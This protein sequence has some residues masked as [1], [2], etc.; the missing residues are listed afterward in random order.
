MLT[1]ADIE[2]ARRRIRDAV[3]LTPFAYTETLSKL[4][5]CKVHL[6][7]ENLQ[8]T[9]SFKER[10]ALN[11][12][13]GLPPD[14]R[15]RGV[16]TASAGNHAQG[17]AYHCQ[18]LGIRATIVMP[19]GT[20]L[21]KVS[22]TRGFGAGVVLHGASYDD[23]YGEALRLS[24]DDGMEMVHPFDDPEV[25]AGQGTIGLELLEQ[26]PY[27]DMVVTSIGGGG[28]VA[29]VAVALKETNPKIKVIGVEAAA[30]PAMRQS[31]DAGSVVTLPAARTI[32]DGIAV[33]PVGERTF[34][35]VQPYVAEGGGGAPLAARDLGKVPSAA[36]K[37]GG[38]IVSG[39]NID[40][41]VV[42]RII[43]RGLVKSGR[44]MRVFVRITDQIGSLAELTTRIAEAGAGILQI[45]HNRAFSE[46]P[47][48]A[49]T[50]ELVLETKGFA[51]IDDVSAALRAAGYAIEVGGPSALR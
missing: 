27:L 31:R 49:A 18:R 20:P 38:L 43:E 39:G 12:I 32:A 16:V 47:V 2:A 50:V 11:K 37:R 14:A 46:G 1:F 8:M 25:M 45:H 9:G 30:I 15:T 24:R 4:C 26:N 6:K 21:I 17:V 13:L 34:P 23:A 48:G 7:L 10:G 44:L 42:S 35:I 33:R 5:G 29:G 51:H 19:K 22:R 40:V 3:Y 41:N 36:G 28:L